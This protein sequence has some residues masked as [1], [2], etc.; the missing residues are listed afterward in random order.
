MIGESEEGRRGVLEQGALGVPVRWLLWIRSIPE[1]YRH[2][3]AVISGFDPK[4]SWAMGCWVSTFYRPL[5][6]RQLRRL[7]RRRAATTV[8]VGLGWESS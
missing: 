1:Y 4:T 5:S 7:L 2:T 6:A 3:A 8:A